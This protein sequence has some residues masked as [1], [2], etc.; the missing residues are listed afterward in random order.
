MSDHRPIEPPTDGD[1]ART[2]RLD[3]LAVS[4]PAEIGVY[5]NDAIATICRA[6]DSHADARTVVAKLVSDRADAIVTQRD[7]LVALIR[8]SRAAGA[9]KEAAAAQAARMTE[10]LGI[11]DMLRAV[12]ALPLPETGSADDYCYVRRTDDAGDRISVV[13]ASAV[14][15]FEFDSSVAFTEYAKSTAIL[16]VP[17]LLAF[18]VTVLSGGPIRFL[19]GVL[20]VMILCIAVPTMLSI[21]AGKPT[22]A[23]RRWWNEAAIEGARDFLNGPAQEAVAELSS[24]ELAVLHAYT[25]QHPIWTTAS[26][27]VPAANG[28]SGPVFAALAARAMSEHADEREQVS[29]WVKAAAP[30]LNTYV[31]AEYHPDAAGPDEQR[32]MTAL[33]DALMHATR[34]RRLE[35]EIVARELRASQAAQRALSSREHATRTLLARLDTER[36]DQ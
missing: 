16:A 4:T 24:S 13:P 10:L 29:A 27:S 28:T 19:S 2:R 26:P 9:A 3:L 18:I 17:F 34:N 14:P 12:S 20:L 11:V 25:S 6:I 31:A 33:A 35:Q 30:V 1:A 32:A 21:R 23:M 8:D 22:S 15:D 36:P 7:D 5:G